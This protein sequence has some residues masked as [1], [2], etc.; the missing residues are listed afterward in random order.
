MDHGNH[1]NLPGQQSCHTDSGTPSPIFLQVR[2][3]KD[4]EERY[5][6]SVDSKGGCGPTISAKTRQNTVVARKCGKQSTYRHEE[7]Q[8][9]GVKIPAGRKTLPNN[10][11]TPA[12]FVKSKLIRH[13]N[14]WK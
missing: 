6:T 9:Q 10:S 4:L 13:V 5:T 3:L 11:N 1:Q 14:C 8:I 12:E 2:I 7:H